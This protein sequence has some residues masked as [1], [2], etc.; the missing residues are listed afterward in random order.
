MKR[1]ILTADSIASSKNSSNFFVHFNIHV[2]I[3]SNLFVSGIYLRRNPFIKW[4]SNQSVDYIADILSWKLLNLF[5]HN[6]K[7]LVDR[8]IL[9][10]KWKDILHSQSLILRNMN[11]LHILAIDS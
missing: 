4:F 6:R 7:S 9:L 5:L 2:A 8:D 1:K 11:I 3:L 10:P